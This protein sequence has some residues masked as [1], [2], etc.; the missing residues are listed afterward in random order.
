M[1]IPEQLM[2]PPATNGAASMSNGQM[3]SL[4]AQLPAHT[5]MQEQNQSHFYPPNGAQLISA[6]ILEPTWLMTETLTNAIL[7]QTRSHC[8]TGRYGFGESRRKKSMRK[9]SFQCSYS[10]L[11]E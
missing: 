5:E 2:P 10:S 8:M 7:V 6:G 4:P 9:L 1:D 3:R 11:I